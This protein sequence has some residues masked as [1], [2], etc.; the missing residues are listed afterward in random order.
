MAAVLKEYLDLTQ[1]LNELI[2]LSKMVAETYVYIS[3]T[4]YILT[5]NVL[6]RF[7]TLVYRKE[8]LGGEAN[9]I[10]FPL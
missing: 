5:T 2:T 8:M 4:R 3:R 7:V 9:N 10:V 1:A 6:P